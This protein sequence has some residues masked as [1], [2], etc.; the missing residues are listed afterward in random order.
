MS[1]NIDSSQAE[2]RDRRLNAITGYD[3][4][5]KDMVSKG[6]CGCLKNKKRCFSTASDCSHSIAICQL[7]GVK[8]AVIVDHA[9]L[10]CSAGQIQFNNVFN[11]RAFKDAEN[12]HILSTNIRE[13]DTVFG[14]IAKLKATI[15]EAYDRYHPPVIYVISSCVAGIIGEDIDQAVSDMEKE[16][17]ISIGVAHSNGIK[18]KVW[19]S[20]FDD[21]CHAVAK[22]MLKKS[23]KRSKTVNYVGFM[24]FFK[25]YM[26]PFIN[27]MGYDI[28][29][30]TAH[31]TREDYERACESELS[32]AQCGAQ[33]G[34]LCG[35]LEQEFGIKYFVSHQ[36]YGI[37]GFERFIRDIGGYLHKEDI[38]EEIIL[39]E[40]E[41][42][43]DR[44]EKIRERLKGKKG[45]IAAGA[46][47]SNQ[48]ARILTEYGMEVLHSVSF[49]YDPKLDNQSADPIPEKA[50]VDELNLDFPTSVNDLQQLEVINVLRNTKP[51]VLLSK[52][53]ETSIWGTRLG[54]PTVEFK[55]GMI[56]MG[57][58]AFVEL[59]ERI[60][61]EIDN[62]NFAKRVSEH[63]EL[64]FSDEYKNLKPFS[65]YEGGKTE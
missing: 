49:H 13:K 53:H 55:I 8:G 5:L 44:I 1:I 40:R 38:A 45:V 12:W 29:Y 54:I 47:L 36:P 33:G 52:V 15:K 9:P 26:E 35:V 61:S 7:A 63:Y 58:R 41:K 25:E 19:A 2:V 11:R 10:G 14:G 37:S 28:I 4:T 31:A 51:D 48:F 56:A 34:Y 20:G 21:F 46:S 60:I 62:A 6:C 30:L 16:L 64:P 39:E 42:Y 24:P 65:F 43:K 59:G 32:F 3:G 22:T 57:Y 50:D 27:R 18:S 17:G 23:E